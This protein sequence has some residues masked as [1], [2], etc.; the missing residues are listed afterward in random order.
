MTYIFLFLFSRIYNYNIVYPK[1]AVVLNLWQHVRDDKSI[2]IDKL[3]SRNEK[4]QKYATRCDIFEVLARVCCFRMPQNSIMEERWVSPF[5]IRA[6]SPRSLW[7][8]KL[9]NSNANGLQPRFSRCT[10]PSMQRSRSCGFSRVALVPLVDTV[11][12]NPNLRFFR[13]LRRRFLATAVEFPGKLSARF[14]ATSRFRYLVSSRSFV[15][16][17]RHRWK[18]GKES[19]G[20]EHNWNRAERVET[21]LFCES[22]NTKNHVKWE[23]WIFQ[24]R[25]LFSE[26]NLI[27]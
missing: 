16:W 2:I 14:S 5:V 21:F 3:T 6:G 11:T 10:P 12:F 9:V 26:L 24:L 25:F 19:N 13:R 23:R 20:K 27:V 22:T 4:F 17:K 8:R 1:K 15:K 18:G 7:N